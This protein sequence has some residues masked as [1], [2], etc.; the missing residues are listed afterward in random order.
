MYKHKYV[1]VYINNICMYVCVHM[2]MN[3]HMKSCVWSLVDPD[4]GYHTN[5]LGLGERL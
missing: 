2:C 1:H 3:V 5:T 4:T